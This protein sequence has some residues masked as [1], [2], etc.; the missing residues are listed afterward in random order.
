MSKTSEDMQDMI[1]RVYALGYDVG[2][3]HHSEIG[4]VSNIYNDLINQVNDTA[5]RD[6]LRQYY[7]KGKEDG[8]KRRKHDMQAHSA[9]KIKKSKGS[10][11]YDHEISEVANTLLQQPQMLAMP[12]HILLMALLNQPEILRGFRLFDDPGL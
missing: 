6:L 4:W 10:V 11:L 2:Y 9:E 3:H 12:K 7:N 1:K 8:N 5:F